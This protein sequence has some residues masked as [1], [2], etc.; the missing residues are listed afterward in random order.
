MINF[1][2]KIKKDENIVEEIMWYGIQWSKLV[3]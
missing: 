1:I 3:E 2:Y